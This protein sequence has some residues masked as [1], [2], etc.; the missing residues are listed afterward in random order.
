VQGKNYTP[1]DVGMFR[2]VVQRESNRLNLRSYSGEGESS[3]TLALAVSA[4]MKK[5]F[6]EKSKMTFSNEPMLEKK[7]IT[8]FVHRMRVDAMEKFNATTIFSTLQFAANEEALEQKQYMVTLVVYLEKEFLPEFLRL[9]DYPY[10]DSDEDDECKD[11]CGTLANLIGGQYKRELASLGYKDLEMSPFQSFI[12]TA[13]DGVG[14]PKDVTEKYEISFEVEGTKRLVVEMAALDMLPK[15]KT[16]EKKGAKRI[17]VIDDDT[18]FI[19]GI[20]PFLRSQ[21][22]DV[23]VAYNGAEGIKKLD[24]RPH[25]IIL[26][27]AMPVM[28]GY[29]F[30]IAKK[31][32]Q[33]SEQV[34][35]IVLTVKQDIAE[36]LKAEG[37]KDCLPKP[38]H[39]MELLKSIERHV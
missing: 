33:G 19:K 2:E 37:V 31:K 17:L 10:I 25:L 11:G 4:A 38:F 21:G 28:D 39:P 13:A 3:F 32:I 5:I 36:L 18:E 27:M 20:E 14:I 26:D 1:L 16:H 34:P 8:Q 22:F 7:V 12:N 6:F 23:I 30:I 24:V 29:E 35:V 15:W 9:L